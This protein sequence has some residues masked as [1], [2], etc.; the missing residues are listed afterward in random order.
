MRGSPFGA[1]P[2]ADEGAFDRL[3]ESINPEWIEA[4]LEATGTATVRRRRLPAEQVI[5]LV[6]GMAIYR[7][8]PIDDLVA[9]LDLSLPGTGSA[10]MAKSA[11][12]Q[13]RARLGDEPLK[14]L[15]ERCSEKWAHESARRHAW[16]GL[17][18]YGVDGT[19]V[20]V[21]DSKENRTHFGS[22]NT[23]NNQI[24]GYP[25][26]RIVTLMALRSHILAAAAFGPWGDER[27]YATELW[28]KVPDDSLMIVDRNF[29][30]AHILV[31]LEAT[32]TNRH[33]LTRATAN[34][35]WTVVKKLGPGDE[36][37]EMMPSWGTRAKNEHVPRVWTMRAIH[38][39]R[40]GF[41]PQTLLTS[42]VDAKLF[43][44]NEL[45][46]LYHERWEI[47]EAQT[48][49]VKSWSASRW[50][51]EFSSWFVDRDIAA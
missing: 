42:L 22:Q 48:Q 15:F 17:A 37:V 36:L 7:Q 19:T 4:A 12:A 9:H 39:R 50:S 31:G 26:A 45:R 6:L 21:P 47:E 14:W 23:R 3:R 28:P 38:Y 40:P 25:L 43:P 5:W 8:R 51:D 27:P 10:S 24:S 46:A 11:I 30:A 2:S 49:T 34:S 35:K 13:A 20:R 16:R 32:G 29:L 44:A 18:L 1:V 33:W 41:K